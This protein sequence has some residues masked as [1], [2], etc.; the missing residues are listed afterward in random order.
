VYFKSAIADYYGL[1][2]FAEP[3]LRTTAKSQDADDVA[4]VNSD[5]LIFWKK[6]G[7]GK[8]GP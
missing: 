4:V 8:I 5:F 6:L 2:G 3:E 7:V 1:R